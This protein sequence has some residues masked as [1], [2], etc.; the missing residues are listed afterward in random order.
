[1]P[2]EKQVGRC[3]LACRGVIYNTGRCRCPSSASSWSIRFDS[4]IFRVSSACSSF[5]LP[6]ERWRGGRGMRRRS[7]AWSCSPSC[8]GHCPTLPTGSSTWSTSA[9]WGSTPPWIGFLRRGSSSTS[10]DCR[11]IS[12]GAR[13]VA[14]VEFVGFAWKKKWFL[15][16]IWLA[17]RE[18]RIG[19][20]GEVY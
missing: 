10:G 5:H 3:R 20:G 2:S 16:E 11:S 4:S 8:T 9:R 6:R 7:S 15:D 1:M 13:W 14:S 18:A 19:G 17:G 12:T